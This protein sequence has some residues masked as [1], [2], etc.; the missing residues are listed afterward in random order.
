MGDS[1]CDEDEN[2]FQYDEII[3]IAKKLLVLMKNVKCRRLPTPK[4]VA[5]FVDNCTVHVFAS[6][7]LHNNLVKVACEMMEDNVTNISNMPESLI[8]IYKTSQKNF[9]QWLAQK[10]QTEYATKQQA[11]QKKREDEIK[12]MN[13]KKKKKKK[14]K[15][16]ILSPNEFK[17]AFGIEEEHKQS[18]A[19]QQQPIGMMPELDQ[20]GRPMDEEKKQEQKEQNE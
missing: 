1:Q 13:E 17:A 16:K 18:N 12:K 9:S 19:N 2:V 7:L 3:D 20:H 6:L 10:F 8:R 14:Q 15:N 5:S 11:L 4:D